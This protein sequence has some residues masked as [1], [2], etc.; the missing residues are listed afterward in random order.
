MSAKAIFET[1]LV[2]DGRAVEAPAHM[3][4]LQQAGGID[5]SGFLDAAAAKLPNYHSLRIDFKPPHSLISTATSLVMPG[6]FN[7]QFVRCTL[8]TKQLAGKQLNDGNGP[9]KVSDRRNLEALEAQT[10]PAFPLLIDGTNK[11]LE[12]TRHNVFIIEGASIVTPPLDGRI[13]PGITRQVALE[14]AQKLGIA[15]L[16]EPITLERAIS[17]DGMF[18]TNALIGIGWVEQ[19]DDTPW[20]VI[21]LVAKRLHTALAARWAP[22]R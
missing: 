20:P 16:E 22:M 17:A 3:R 14:L 8:F 9:L 21:P 19:C 13:L 1:L 11:I 15:H 4:R 6:L 2:I 7:G 12:T 5:A 18:V 10:T